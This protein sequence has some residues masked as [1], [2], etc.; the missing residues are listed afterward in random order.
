MNS[1]WIK[2]NAW[3]K[4]NRKQHPHSVVCKAPAQQ[5]NVHIENIRHKLSLPTERVKTGQ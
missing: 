5:T 3:V 2:V 1:D 4:A